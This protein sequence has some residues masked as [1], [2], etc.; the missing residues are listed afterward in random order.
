MNNAITTHTPAKSMKTVKLYQG[1]SRTFLG[2]NFDYLRGKRI[3]RRAPAALPVSLETV[4]AQELRLRDE[5]RGSVR[6]FLARARTTLEHLSKL[7]ADTER[8]ARELEK[9]GALLPEATA[10]AHKRA[11]TWEMI[12]AV[13]LILCEVGG[14]MWIMRNA[15]GLPPAGAL[16]IAAAT[17]LM[18]SASVKVV[19]AT[20]PERYRPLAK[21]VL[22]IGGLLLAI[23]GLVGV[24]IL[25]EAIFSEALGGGQLN[26]AQMTLGSTISITG[27]TIGLPLT[28]GVLWTEAQETLRAARSSLDLF[29]TRARYEEMAGQ[30]RI[31]LSSMEEVDARLDQVAERVIA[32]RK[33]D[34]IRGFHMGASGNPAGNE[35]ASMALRHAQC[36]E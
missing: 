23:M 3:G 30:W 21:R 11:A 31:A 20:L 8:Q 14:L 7:Q 4:E 26:L 25:R 28:S 16:M 33:G 29:R 19:L 6:Q 24:V 2:I 35:Q 15:F 17:T 10:L 27:M 9:T 5:T 34:I 32:I 12:A 13:F 18:L 22:G 36:G 1:R